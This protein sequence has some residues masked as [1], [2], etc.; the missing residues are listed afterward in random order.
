MLI[1]STTTFK[2]AFFSSFHLQSSL[3]LNAGSL[4]SPSNNVLTGHN[5]CS[6][7]HPHNLVMKYKQCTAKN[8]QTAAKYA[9]SGNMKEISVKI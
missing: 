1:I 9:H 7:L 3:Q 6:H 2:C 4:L 5:A 8:L